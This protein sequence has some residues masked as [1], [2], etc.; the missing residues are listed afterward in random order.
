MDNPSPS[1]SFLQRMALGALFAKLFSGG[2]EGQPAS[3]NRY[4]P[5]NSTYYLSNRGT[6][7]KRK[8]RPKKKFHRQLKKRGKK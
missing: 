8:S 5:G 3:S 6:P 1:K 4:R 2:R 7:A